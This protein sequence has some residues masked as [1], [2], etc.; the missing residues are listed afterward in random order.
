MALLCH[1]SRSDWKH[2]LQSVN[3]TGGRKMTA[4][5]TML[6]RIL[7]ALGSCIIWPAV[8]LAQIPCQDLSRKLSAAKNNMQGRRGT[9]SV[10]A[11]TLSGSGTL[12]MAENR[13]Q[14][15]P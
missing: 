10:T 12:R 8:M 13:F 1:D 14:R 6:T 5:K 15:F 11:H 2:Q 9:V 4:R 3:Q 7:P